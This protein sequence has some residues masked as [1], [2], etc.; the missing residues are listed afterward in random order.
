VLVLLM[1]VLLV[2]G[3]RTVIFCLR[4]SARAEAPNFASYHQVLNAP[5]GAPVLLPNNCRAFWSVALCLTAL[6]SSA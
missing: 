6:W 2:T 5:A 4:V 1:G 3:K